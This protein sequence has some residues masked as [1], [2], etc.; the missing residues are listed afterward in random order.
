MESRLPT[1]TLESTTY[2]VDVDYGLL[3]EKENFTHVLDFHEMDWLKTH[4]AISDHRG[5][6]L[7]IPPMVKLDPE[8]MAL[9]YGLPLADLPQTDDGLKCNAA[10]MAERLMGALPTISICGHEFFVDLRLDLLRPKDDFSTMGIQISHL[11]EMTPNDGYAF[12]YDPATRKQVLFDRSWTQIPR[13]IV[14]VEIPDVVTMDVVGWI[15]SFDNSHELRQKYVFGN[16]KEAL[17]FRW[18]K[19][20]E[21]I[22]N[23]HPIRKGLQARVIPWEQTLVPGLVAQNKA[24]KQGE[25]KSKQGVEKRKDGG[26]F[27]L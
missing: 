12:L 1:F 22:V 10:L 18:G 6:V 25:H 17:N 14:A 2:L 27:K 23:R 26:R 21:N 5:N 16:R 19:S 7:T 8:G 15:Y 4:Y 11:T 3:R 9:K 13:G 20:Y 24:A